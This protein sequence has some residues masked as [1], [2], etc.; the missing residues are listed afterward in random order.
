[1]SRTL[2]PSFARC[3][4]LARVAPVWQV[5]SGRS[6]VP[7][8]IAR[9]VRSRRSRSA[10]AVVRSAPVR[11]RNWQTMSAARSRSPA[12]T[13]KDIASHGHAC[14]LLAM[15]ILWNLP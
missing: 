3:Y 11:T 1:M 5:S 2:S 12:L 9:S 7:A 14:A 15:R 10:L 6:R 13:A 4:G 8:S